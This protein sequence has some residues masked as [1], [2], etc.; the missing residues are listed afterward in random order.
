MNLVD[1][2]KKGDGINLLVKRINGG[3]MVIRLA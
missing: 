1:Y 2:Y 3:L